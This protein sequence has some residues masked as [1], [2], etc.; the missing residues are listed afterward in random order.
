MTDY[1]G[2]EGDAF[3]EFRGIDRDGPIH[4]LNLVKMK[5][6]ATYDDGRTSTGFE[7]YEA[8]GR[9]SGPIFKRVGGRIVWSG[10]MEFMLI[11]P[12]DEQWDFCFVAE[13]PSVDAF[14]EMIKDP[15]YREAMKHRQAGVKTSRLIRMAPGEAG[16]HFG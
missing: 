6:I 3:A 5:E 10:K 14:V 1:T 11:G 13:Y 12:Q 7:A 16:E 8:Y 2:F 9:E 4:M 15:A